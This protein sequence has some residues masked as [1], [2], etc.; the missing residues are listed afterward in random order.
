[1]TT[2]PAGGLLNVPL[3]TGMSVTLISLLTESGKTLVV[4][5]SDGHGGNVP[6]TL[7]I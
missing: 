7:T 3:V 4:T 5:L 6:I 2:L 1:M